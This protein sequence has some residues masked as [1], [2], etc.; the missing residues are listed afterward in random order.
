MLERVAGAEQ[1]EARTASCE[2][3]ATT[4]NRIRGRAGGRHRRVESG[5]RPAPGA[6]QQTL[7]EFLEYMPLSQ[8]TGTTR[9][10]TGADWHTHRLTRKKNGAK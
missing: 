4:R 2:E 7:K 9:A 1:A 10:R 3:W 5:C 6:A 8:H